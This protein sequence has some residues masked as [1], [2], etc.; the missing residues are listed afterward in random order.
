MEAIEMQ[1]NKDDDARHNTKRKGFESKWETI[2]NI[3]AIVVERVRAT[4][5]DYS[6]WE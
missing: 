4:I 1:E 5:N 2:I 6:G 3:I